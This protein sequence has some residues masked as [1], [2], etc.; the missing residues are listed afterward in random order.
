[1]TVCYKTKYSTCFLSFTLLL[2]GMIYCH[3]A[4]SQSSEQGTLLLS[5]DKNC[6]IVFDG[7]N[8]GPF[9]ANDVK[10]IKADIG[11]HILTATFEGNNMIRKIITVGNTTQVIVP[12][13]APLIEKDSSNHI[14]EK[15]SVPEAIIDT[16]NLT[17]EK[18]T[19]LY[20]AELL[21][22]SPVDI[23]RLKYLLGKGVDIQTVDIHGWSLLHEAAYQGDTE[24]VNFCLGKG[25]PIDAKAV[26][27][28]YFSTPLSCAIEQNHPETVKLLLSRNATYGVE[29]GYG[30]IEYDSSNK[31][32][33]N[34]KDGKRSG[35]GTFYFRN[36]AI[37]KGEWVKDKEDGKGIMN[38]PDG[39]KYEGEW[40]DGSRTGEGTF[41][42][43]SYSKFSGD[44][45]VGH[46]EKSKFSGQ[47]IYYYANGNKYEGNYLN[48]KKN[49]HGKVVWE[50][51]D[52][53]EGNWDNDKKSG[54]GTANFANG[55]KY[56]G[57]FEN[58]K[59]AGIGTYYSVNGEKYEGN[60]SNGA[61]NGQGTLYLANGAKYIG[62][63]INGQRNGLGTYYYAGGGRY[64]GNWSNGLK[65][66]QGAFYYFEGSIYAGEWLNDE[67]SG[68]GTYTIGK[69]NPGYFSYCDK[70]KMYKGYWK[71]DVKNGDGGCYDSKGKLI[72]EGKFVNDVPTPPYPNY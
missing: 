38:W 72:Y 46:F 41:T 39:N 33:G 42:Y 70:C 63:W 27:T 26:Y 67:K 12:I 20:K 64:E 45:Y 25:L 16:Q 59:L 68:F 17:K 66:G 18:A 34:F 62:N 3:T 69:D 31:Y 2:C 55:D 29:D 22:P 14:V 24:L 7:E 11:D 52:K 4:A 71:N 10:K 51:G 58:D 44:K 35:H 19:E 5:P 23:G 8:L 30:E 48:G 57:N 53:Y 36:G 65:N 21:R 40:Q 6:I 13:T 60:W 47:G 56:I 32:K 61:K 1:M 43:G 9:S 54:L 50:N 49:G 28:I 15:K 37:Y